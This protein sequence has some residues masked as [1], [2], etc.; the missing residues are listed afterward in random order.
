MSRVKIIAPGAVI[1]PRPGHWPAFPGD[2][3]EVADHVA[4]GLIEKGHAEMVEEEAG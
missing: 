1:A 2:V 3:I 4:T